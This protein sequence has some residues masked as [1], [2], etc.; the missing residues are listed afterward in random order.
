M[1]LTVIRQ[2]LESDGASS[3]RLKQLDL[4]QFTGLTNSLQNLLRGFK[5]APR[6]NEISYLQNR[7]QLIDDLQ[8]FLDRY[9]E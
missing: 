2:W 5:G 7:E 4:N 1:N 9:N 6:L 3:N 8:K